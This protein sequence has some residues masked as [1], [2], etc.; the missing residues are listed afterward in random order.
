M[1]TFIEALGIAYKRGFKDG[2]QMDNDISD[3]EFEETIAS[4]VIDEAIEKTKNGRD[5]TE[6]I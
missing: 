5:I 2:Y 3:E 1:K 4:E 6:N